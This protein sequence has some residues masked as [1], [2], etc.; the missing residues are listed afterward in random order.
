VVDYDITPPPPWTR[1]FRL[2]FAGRVVAEKGV[3]DLVEIM[4]RVLSRQPGQFI[5]SICGDGA[6]FEELKDRVERA[7][8]ESHVTLLGWTEPR[9]LR[10]IIQNAH[11]AIVPTRSS[12]A[13]GMAMAALEPIL[14]GRPVITNRTVPAIQ[15][16][17]SACLEARTDDIES[18]VECILSLS[19]A[20][21]TYDK[22]VKGCASAR[23]ELLRGDT[24]LEVVLHKAI[25]A[26]PSPTQ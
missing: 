24:S 21:K 7:G 1:P 26:K 23:S 14:L 6:D 12:F 10:T 3:F 15:V 20:P 19:R 22:L 25:D 11:A 5:L 18:Y 17:R 2:I 13:E 16:A 4:Q 9:A 8:L